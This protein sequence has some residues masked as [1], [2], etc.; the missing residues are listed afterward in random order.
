MLMVC[1]SRYGLRLLPAFLCG[2]AVVSTVPR[3]LAQGFNAN[4]SIANPA[5]IG[6]RT[7]ASSTPGNWPSPAPDNSP[8]AAQPPPK[9][10]NHLQKLWEVLTPDPIPT[11]PVP[12][13][14][15][16]NDAPAVAPADSSAVSFR[17]DYANDAV[18]KTGIHNA[19]TGSEAWSD[20]VGGVGSVE[21]SVFLPAKK[22][23]PGIGFRI[24]PVAIRPSVNATASYEKMT[25]AQSASPLNG[26][27]PGLGGTLDLFI[28]ELELRR[29]LEISYAAQYT[30]QSRNSGVRPY[31]QDLEVHGNYAFSKL[32]LG[33]GITYDALSG[34]SRD[35]GGQVNRDLLTVAPTATYEL[36]PKTNLEWDVTMPVREYS[37]GTD[38]S[39]LTST[40]FF[41]YLYSDKTQVGI[42]FAVGSLDVIGEGQQRFGQLLTRAVLVS[43]EVSSFYGTVG[44]E[45][46]EAGDIRELNPIFGLGAQW[47]PRFG[48][49]FSLTAGRAVQSSG[50]M[51]DSN[52]TTTDLAL[53]VTQR[54]GSQAS[55]TFSA[56]Y[57]DA[58]YKSTQSVINT[59][60]HDRLL[61]GQISLQAVLTKRWTG[62]LVYSY[63]TNYSNLEPYTDS[64][65]RI[66][67]SFTY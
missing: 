41:N 56:G 25:G 44:V 12:T 51:I 6:F 16:A 23:A 39:G 13:Q 14:P 45:Y 57:E 21:D 30:Y 29:S 7:A 48:T 54:L 53:A 40:T 59:N 22:A 9:P 19:K 42:G 32:N 60:R 50:D 43:S 46:R 47:I 33:L 52:Y 34:T 28:G 35:F 61:F 49:A 24:G 26:F 11:S 18:V 10:E 27:H 5:I 36:S 62:S 58:I 8:D 37:G 15:A 1:L 55:L 67:L 31:T 63:R 66:Q 64:L 3:L 65:A 20:G 17:T 4:T 2:A 38:S